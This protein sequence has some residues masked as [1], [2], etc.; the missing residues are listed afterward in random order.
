MSSARRDGTTMCCA[1]AAGLVNERRR[2]GAVCPLAEKTAEPQTA[3]PR[4]KINAR[5]RNE[6]HSLLYFGRYTIG[7][8]LVITRVRLRRVANAMYRCTKGR[9]HIRGILYGEENI[10]YAL[11]PHKARGFALYSCCARKISPSRDFRAIR[12]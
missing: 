7:L 2:S 4:R 6:R 9:W 12:Y 8:V 5:T 11:M 3:V 10:S 1:Y